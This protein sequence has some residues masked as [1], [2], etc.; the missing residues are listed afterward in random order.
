MAISET[1]ICNSALTKIGV[2]RI[3]SLEDNTKEGILCNEQY[4]KLRDEVLLSH[5]WN[6]AQARAELAEDS[7]TPA[8][9]WDKQYIIPSDVLR[10]LYMHDIRDLHQ[11]VREGN[12]L[13]TNNSDAKIVYI[14]QITD[15]SLFSPRFAETLALRIAWD[16]AYALVQS[17]QLAGQMEAAYQRF[18]SASRSFNAQEGREDNLTDDLFINSRL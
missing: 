7:V 14:K 6:F 13:L 2:E 10:V 4:A 12:L 18:L 3:T 9:G 11:F 1:S 8:F 5:P 17:T 16:L 15:T